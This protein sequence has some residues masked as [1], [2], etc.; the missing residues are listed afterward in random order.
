VSKD[1]ALLELNRRGG[2]GSAIVTP[3][4]VC[5]RLGLIGVTD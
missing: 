2:L 5:H 1:R 4:E 3:A